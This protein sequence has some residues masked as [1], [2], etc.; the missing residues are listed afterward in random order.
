MMLTARGFDCTKLSQYNNGEPYIDSKNNE[1][2]NL[3]AALYNFSGEYTIN[4]PIFALL[5]LDMG[6]YTIPDN[7][8]WTRENLINVILDYH[9]CY[10]AQRYA[11]DEPDS[12]GDDGGRCDI[13]GSESAYDLCGRR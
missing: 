10:G 1:I 9:H 4:G 6:N 7:A 2:D 3:V 12:E 8:R 13:A 5:A 11:P